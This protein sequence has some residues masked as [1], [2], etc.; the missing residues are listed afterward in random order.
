MVTIQAALVGQAAQRFKEPRLR[1]RQ[2]HI[3][4]RHTQ[5]PFKYKHALLKLAPGDAPLAHHFSASR[6]DCG[7]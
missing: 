7:E 5:F 3:Q 2:F 6:T 1:L 4:R